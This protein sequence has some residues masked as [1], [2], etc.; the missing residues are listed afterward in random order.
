MDYLSC[1]VRDIEDKKIQRVREVQKHE[2][3]DYHSCIGK[4]KEETG[5]IQ[6]KGKKQEE[7]LDHVK[8]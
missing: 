4:D 8:T 7:V 2:I 3:L 5:K 6:T 1:I